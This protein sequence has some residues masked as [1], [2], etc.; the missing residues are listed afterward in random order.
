[1]GSTF[2]RESA[3]RNLQKNE[4]GRRGE[5]KQWPCDS[6]AANKES[7]GSSVRRQMCSL[8]KL[9]LTERRR[10]YK[11]GIFLDLKWVSE[12][13]RKGG[14]NGARLTKTWLEGGGGT[15]ET[16]DEFIRPVNKLH[17]VKKTPSKKTSQ[18]LQQPGKNATWQL[19]LR[20]KVEARV[21]IG[22]G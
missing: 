18:S 1:M 7:E 9:W 8:I 6:R 5:K 2:A 20:F 4:D 21:R 14:I 13:Q 3:F 11:K 12:L 15:G 10:P 22:Y 17:S 16:P 19:L